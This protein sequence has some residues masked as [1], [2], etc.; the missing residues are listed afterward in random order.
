MEEE[1]DRAASVVWGIERAELD[2]IRGA[3]Y[4]S[5]AVKPGQ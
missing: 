4:E 2:S 1:I 3:L 5:R